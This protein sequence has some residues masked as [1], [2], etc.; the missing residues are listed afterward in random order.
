[1]RVILFMDRFLGAAWVGVGVAIVVTG[2]GVARA[3]MRG[4]QDIFLIL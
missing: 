4:K 2:D 3:L 1:M